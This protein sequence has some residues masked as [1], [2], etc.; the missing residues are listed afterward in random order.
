MCNDIIKVQN[1]PQYMYIIYT[2]CFV[3]HLKLDMSY[4][5]LF[6]LN[7]YRFKYFLIK[8]LLFEIANV[9]LNGPP[10]TKLS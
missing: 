8:F 1:V 5:C 7:S 10:L 3:F 9:T 6:K 4:T 2:V